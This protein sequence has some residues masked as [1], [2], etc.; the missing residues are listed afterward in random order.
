LQYG[1]AWK[2]GI[3][4]RRLA[5]ALT[6]ETSIL[7][8]TTI[9][10]GVVFGFLLSYI[11][12]IENPVLSNAAFIGITCSLLGLLFILLAAIYLLGTLALRSLTQSTTL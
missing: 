9:P 6:I 11:F 1:L 4:R 12:L 5:I 10:S 8:I 2:I 3:P 7:L